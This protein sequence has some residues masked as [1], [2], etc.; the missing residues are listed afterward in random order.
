MELILKLN[1]EDFKIIMRE[2]FPELFNQKK[3][4]ELLTF[5][6]TLE[7]LHIS[8][9]CLNQWKAQGKIP[10]KKL[11]KRIFFSRSEIME[12]LREAGNYNKL[13]KLK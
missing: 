7:L 10:F 13:Q 9:S 12:S 5:K 2:S 6:E 8:A 11:G 4:K 3:E 1:D